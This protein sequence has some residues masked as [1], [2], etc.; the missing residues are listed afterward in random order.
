MK[1][2]AIY[3]LGFFD[4]VHLGHQA[5]LKECC[6]LAQAQGCEPAALT[7]RQAPA[8]VLLNQYPNT[9]STLHDRATLLKAYGIKTVMVFET[10]RETLSIPWQD[11]LRRLMDEGAVGFVC[12]NDFR[13]GQNGAGNAALLA[14][15]CAQNGL[16]CQIVPDQQMHGERISSTRIRKLLEDGD[17]DQANRLLGHPYLLTGGVTKGKQ[18]GRTLDFPTANLELPEGMLC[19]KLGVYACKALVDGRT[20]LAVTNIGNRP[21]VSGEG[22]TVEAHLLDFYGDLY[23]KA[24]TLSFFAFLRPEQKFASLEELTAEIQKNVQQTRNFFEKSE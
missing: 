5:L 13:F 24:L 12:G 23:G 4:G 19:P 14:E 2:Q 15:F 9:I 7:F 10:D 21:T 6:A 11:F 20:F 17:L 22:I 8:A 1:E 16:V 3:A 18:L